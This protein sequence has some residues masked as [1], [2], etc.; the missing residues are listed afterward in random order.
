MSLWGRARRWVPLTG[1]GLA[2][3]ARAGRCSGTCPGMRR[4]NF[5]PPLSQSRTWG[6]ATQEVRPK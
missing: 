3:R 4:E 6:L 1:C 2:F 5:L